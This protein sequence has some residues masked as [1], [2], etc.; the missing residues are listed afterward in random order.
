[1]E[2][3]LL[4]WSLAGTLDH[5]KDFNY[6]FDNNSPT[7]NYNR[8]TTENSNS[9]KDVWKIAISVSSDNHMFSNI[10]KFDWYH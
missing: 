1:M 4:V 2:L 6:S 3:A 8:D 10:D 7:P 9:I 5:P